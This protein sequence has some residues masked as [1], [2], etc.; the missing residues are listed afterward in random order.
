M[1]DFTLWG[2][3]AVRFRADP[4][5]GVGGKFNGVHEKRIRA[6]LLE[7][8]IWLDDWKPNRFLRVDYDIYIYIYIYTAPYYAIW[9]AVLTSSYTSANAPTLDAWTVAEARVLPA[10][11]APQWFGSQGKKLAGSCDGQRNIG[12]RIQ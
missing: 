12:H 6:T 2:L 3:K 9:Y 10:L 4:G 11:L 5:M 7:G 8:N 1:Y